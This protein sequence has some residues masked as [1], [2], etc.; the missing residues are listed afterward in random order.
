MIQ[1]FRYIGLLI[2]LLLAGR[3][4]AQVP[5]LDSVCPGALRHYRVNGQ[6]A[7]TYSWIL[8]EP[9][10]V[11]TVQP[12]TADTVEILWNYAPGTY[13]LKVVQHP[14]YGCDADTVY[15]QIHLFDQ[16]FVDAG[17]DGQ[18]CIDGTYH[19][20]FAS[21][22]YT[23]SVLWTTAGDGTFDDP[24]LLDATYTPGTNDITNGSVILTLT[25]Y[26]L[27]DP[28]T[29]D[30]SVSSMT[31]YIT[32]QV[33]PT[34]EPIGTLCQY[35]EPPELDTISA[36]DISGTWTPPVI[37]TNVPGTFFFHFTP[38]EGECAVPLDLRVV[39]DS[40]PN[41]YAGADQTIAI[42]SS[43]SINDATA[44][45][46]GPLTY[47]WTP[48]VLLLDPTVLHPTTVSLSATTAFILTATDSIGC[49]N[50]DT[51]IIFIQ[52]GPLEVNPVALP[53]MICYGQTVQLFANASGGTG[54]YTY[55]WT[56]SPAGFSSNLANP[57]A[58]PS[59][60]TIYTVVVNDGFATVTG[61]VTVVVNPLPQAYAGADQVIS[62]GTSTVIA[63]ATASGTEPLS[64]FWTPPGMLVD[65]T[66]L[67]P[68]TVNLFATTIFTLTV[69]DA[70]GCQ[71]SDAMTIYISNGPLVVSPTAEPDAICFGG[72]VQLHANATG[73]TGTYTYSWTSNP[74]GF[75]STESDPIASPAVT[76]VYTVVVN[77]GLQSVSG[78]VTVVVNPLPLVYAG[79]DQTILS[80]TST[81]I[82]DATASG[83]EPLIYEWTPAALLVD[84]NVL[85]PT[86][87]NLFATT[88]FT[89]T[90]TDANG[91][92]D[93][94]HVTIF[95]EGGAL[96]VKPEAIPESICLGG[97]AQLFANASGGTGT[98]IY[99]WTS[100]PPG[101]LSTL[102]NPVVSPSVT[103]IYT[104][105]V[106]DGSTIV[107]GSVTLTVNPLPDVFAGIDQTIPTG[108]S[109][110]I[111]DATASGSGPLTYHWEPAGMLTDPN[112]LNPVTVNLNISTTFTLTVTDINGC[113]SS[114]EMIVTVQ[115]GLLAVNPIAVPDQ[116]CI[117]QSSQL[118]A[119][120]SG[121]SGTYTFSWSSV[122]AGFSSTVENPMVNPSVTTT[123]TVVVNDGTSTAS[124]DVT[125]TV[126]PLPVVLCPDNFNIC[127]SADP[128][129]LSGGAPEG[130]VYSGPAVFLL[131]STYY[132]DPAIGQGQYLITYTYNDINSCSNSCTFTITVTKHPDVIQTFVGNET[133]S[134]QDGSIGILATGGTPDIFYSIDNGSTWQ[135]NNGLFQN[136][137]AGIYQCIVKDNYDC[138]TSFILVVVN[139]QIKDLEAVT[140]PDDHC[141]GNAAVIW[142][143]VDKFIGVATFQL[144]LSYNKDNLTCEG[145]QH[146][147]SVLANNF[148]GW[149]DQLNGVITLNW[150]SSQPVTLLGVT[151][152][153]ELVFNTKQAGQGQLDW[154]TGVTESYF[155]DINGNP[156]DATFAS[157]DIMIYQP[158]VI[159]NPPVKNACVGESVTLKAAASVTYAPVTYSWTYPDGSHHS[160]DPSFPSVSMANAGD[161]ILLAT[162]AMGCTDQQVIRL[163]V[164]ELPQ[165]L[166]HGTDTLTV[167]RR[168]ILDAGSGMASYLWNTDATSESIT[169]FEEG[170]YWVRMISN[171]NCI[172]I[173]S[174]YILLSGEIPE[175]CLYVPNAFTPDQDGLND[176]FKVVA[177]C[178]IEDFHMMIFNRWGEELYETDDISQGWD[179]TKYGKDIPG[180]VYVY[181]ITY[182]SISTY[183]SNEPQLVTGTVL[184]LE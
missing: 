18:I 148:S 172:G 56:S 92:T 21:A 52:G 33:I 175:V 49:S 127:K 23:G 66:V 24:M 164:S 147:Q 68:Q 26:G 28:S 60:T 121:G 156:I 113:A 123:Y 118:F 126:N 63:D 124:G 43:T 88:L 143:N 149:I 176:T 141:L 116:V 97:T 19:N 81:S 182:R 15:G 77:D 120:P 80:G 67:N 108:S 102:A 181:K 7:S 9:S 138:D 13:I 173:D 89:L 180:D 158:P 10:G 35:S 85:N 104:V 50:T 45:G 166:F 133:N 107:S 59:V 101:F 75:T 162:D 83:A 115:G 157:G 125:V 95:V 137:S 54:N 154:Y 103:T 2:L 14:L 167:P 165:A 171:A 37:S 8:A 53:D 41:V 130:G 12:S 70:N 132:F 73:G 84:P 62:T 6:A 169:I 163:N 109:T 150:S 40:V 144:K 183:P 74:P 100:N 110:S 11:S 42:Y 129:A 34:F 152:V 38:D 184:K 178:P 36:N 134:Q 114:D 78:S 99:S 72:V 136:L 93:H 29:C 5:V 117:G 119:N 90:V 94:D 174:V 155:W 112:V 179:G 27:G 25:G 55:T 3:M 4:A 44:S 140:G 57:V 58:S 79:D 131:G 159:L 20:V 170:W 177:V 142:I 31:L 151:T 122:P 69:T 106:S 61:T 71:R 64:Y 39:V 32:T 160:E 98:Y 153:C 146:L 111:T 105:Q 96:A 82:G 135:S 46:T 139:D 48:A 161:Y 86:T 87:V 168:Y 22:D 51:V 76:T 30:P 47:S 128:I 65:P 16:P 17:P 91:C 1:R 145:Y